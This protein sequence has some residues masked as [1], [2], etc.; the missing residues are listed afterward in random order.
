MVPYSPC[1]CVDGHRSDSP[2][3]REGIT[4][5]GRVL[6]WFSRMQGFIT[7]MTIVM[8][9]A[10]SLILHAY[11]GTKAQSVQERERERDSD[12]GMHQEGQSGRALHLDAR[13]ARQPLQLPYFKHLFPEGHDNHYNS[14]VL[15]VFGKKGR[16]NCRETITTKSCNGFPAVSATSF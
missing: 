15:R 11:A 8:V 6:P 1:P 16:R 4:S 3:L 2:T 5:A 13:R 12:H 7:R 10:L 14:P 9:V